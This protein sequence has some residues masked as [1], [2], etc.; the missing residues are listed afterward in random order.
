MEDGS[1][2]TAFRTEEVRTQNAAKCLN[3]K[4]KGLSHQAEKGRFHGKG[5]DRAGGEL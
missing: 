1:R 2:T 5:S 4:A 3:P